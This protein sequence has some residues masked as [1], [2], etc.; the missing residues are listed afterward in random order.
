M[1]FQLTDPPKEERSREL[2][3]QHAAGFI[4]FEDIRKYALDRIPEDADEATKEMIRKGI[5]DTLYGLMM[6][7]DGV[8]GT[9]S[10][11]EY[12]IGLDTKILLERDGEVMQEIS[13]NR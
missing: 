13:I 9:L 10:N 11:N 3:M 4:I 6:I 1:A 2:W 12:S 5:D 7:M 8:T